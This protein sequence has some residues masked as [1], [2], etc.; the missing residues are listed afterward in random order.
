MCVLSPTAKST[1][2]DKDMNMSTESHHQD[3]CKEH[4]K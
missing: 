1:A 4:L 3:H 2:E